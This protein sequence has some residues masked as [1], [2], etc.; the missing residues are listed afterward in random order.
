MTLNEK[1]MKTSQIYRADYAITSGTAPQ[2]LTF[3]P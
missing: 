3:D 2:P 1:E